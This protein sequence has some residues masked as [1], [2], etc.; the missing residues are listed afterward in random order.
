MRVFACLIGSN[1][2]LVVRGDSK[3]TSDWMTTTLR[4]LL[5]LCVI[6]RCTVRAYLS[7]SLSLSLSTDAA[8]HTPHRAL[9][10]AYLNNPFHRL[11]LQFDLAVCI[12]CVIYF[13][14]Q[15]HNTQT[16]PSRTYICI[17]CLQVHVPENECRS[18][19]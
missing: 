14:H 11:F 9:L 19:T 7:L 4:P 12:A 6:C 16:P 5:K 17:Y 1:L 13:I 10:P 18:L 8:N 3:Q 2:Q 15:N